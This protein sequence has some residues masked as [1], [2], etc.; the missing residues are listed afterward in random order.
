[1]ERL[2]ILD[3]GATRAGAVRSVRV[4][5]RKRRA[6]GGLLR[7]LLAGGLCCAA[8]AGMRAQAPPQPALRNAK[9]RREAS[10]IDAGQVAVGKTVYDQH[11]E[12]CHFSESTA[13][14]VGP[15]LKGIY[16]RG[17]FADRER[18]DNARVTQWIE[19]GG[20]DMPGFVDALKP[21]QIRALLAYMRSL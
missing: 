19:E 12:I 17:R 21:A 20:K 10:A 6:S 15:G 8:A 7:L 5:K 11:C 16:K 4:R 18:V 9:P 1:M 14:K 13:E 3:R 2:G